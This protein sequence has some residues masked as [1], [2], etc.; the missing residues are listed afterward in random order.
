[1]RTSNQ[2]GSILQH[3]TLFSQL[4]MV[5]MLC[6][7][8]FTACGSDE[9]L[10]QTCDTMYHADRPEYTLCKF[11]EHLN[12]THSTLTG[13]D[14]GRELMG[15]NEVWIG[16]TKY[17]A[18]FDNACVSYE[19]V[20]SK[21]RAEARMSLYNPEGTTFESME[22]ENDMPSTHC[23]QP[24]K[25]VRRIKVNVK[26]SDGSGFPVQTMVEIEGAWYILT[27]QYLI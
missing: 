6:A 25:A 12:R 17:D 8:V 11:V 13:D 10:D 15:C 18:N 22:I 9:E 5:I 27:L 3:N 2:I 23:Q 26:L 16:I 24:G 21:F 20:Q 19:L 4:I 1:M 14:I 7:L